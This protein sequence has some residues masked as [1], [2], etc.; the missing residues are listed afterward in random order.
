[1]NFSECRCWHILPHNNSS[2]IILH[3]STLHNIGMTIIL[4]DYNVVSLWLMT[5]N[6][7]LLRIV[8]LLCK[9]KI[10]LF[11]FSFFQSQL[12]GAFYSWLL[13]AD[14]IQMLF[15]LKNS[16]TKR[17][18]TKLSPYAFFVLRPAYFSITYGANTCW[19]YIY[20]Y[21][22]LL[23]HLRANICHAVG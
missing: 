11:S 3:H 19:G 9:K 20:V 7:L 12:F 6:V 18:F 17:K 14:I 21:I 15:V 1:M 13:T 10:A 4:L 2:V 16:E 5:S 23:N 8:L 22:Y